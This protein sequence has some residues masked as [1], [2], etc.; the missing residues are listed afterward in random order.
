MWPSLGGEES[1][2]ARAL[3]AAEVSHVVTFLSVTD[4]AKL[5]QASGGAQGA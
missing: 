5:S 2:R 3:R 1:R 4:W